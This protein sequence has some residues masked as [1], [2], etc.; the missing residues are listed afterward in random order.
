MNAAGSTADLADAL[1]WPASSAGW[2][3]EPLAAVLPGMAPRHRSAPWLRSTAAVLALH[4][5]AA[6]ALLVT[7]T[8][9]PPPIPPAAVM[10]DLAPPSPQPQMAQAAPPPPPMPP[11]VEPEPPPLRKAEVALPKPPPKPKIRPKQPVKQIKPVPPVETPMVAPQVAAEAMPA[12]APAAASVPQT[13][14]PAPVSGNALPTWQGSLLAH[15]ERHKRYPNQ[16]QYRHQQGVATVRFVMDRQGNVLSARLERSSGIASLDEE[17]AALPSR[18]QPLP[19][20]PPEVGG[21]TITLV[22]PV[23]F[24][25]TRR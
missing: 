6:V 4:G 9:P 20:P 12:V 17:A 15:L 11:E 1:G 13:A 3:D 10:I 2:R 25:L 5:L 7:V 16:A 14:P 23:Q 8:V 24:F 21:D 22:V 19:A 18:A